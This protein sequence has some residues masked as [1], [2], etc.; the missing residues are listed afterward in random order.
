MSLTS[1]N[2]SPAELLASQSAS[3]RQAWL[4]SLSDEQALGLQYE[5]RGFWARPSQLPPDNN[6]EW[7]IWLAKPG[8]GWGKTRAGAEWIRH[9]V[10]SG[11]AKDIALVN[12][13]ARDTRDVMV[14]GRDGIV[15]LSPPWC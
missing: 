2:R 7:F 10:E 5:W 11:R 1:A 8:R 13:T 4:N 15:T 9:R 6:A 14:E 3:N 12:D